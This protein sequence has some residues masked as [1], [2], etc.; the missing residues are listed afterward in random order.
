MSN[1]IEVLWTGK[2]MAPQPYLLNLDNVVGIYPSLLNKKAVALMI[3]GAE[4]PLAS[5]FDDVQKLLG[6]PVDRR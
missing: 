4:L 5:T 3:N 2:S 1:F 6:F